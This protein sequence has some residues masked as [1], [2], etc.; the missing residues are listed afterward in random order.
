M[1]SVANNWK[2][3]I[4]TFHPDS[5][6]A[7]ILRLMPVLV[8]G[9][10]LNALSRTAILKQLLQSLEETSSGV[11]FIPAGDFYLLLKQA[12]TSSCNQ[13]GGTK[14]NVDAELSAYCFSCFF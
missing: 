5:G 6:G 8:R 13:T 1:K 14:V 12:K 9:L 10:H 7:G 11:S 2:N 3:W 4:Q